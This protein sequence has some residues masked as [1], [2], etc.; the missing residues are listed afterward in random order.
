VLFPEKK[1]GLVRLSDTVKSNLLLCASV[2]KQLITFYEARKPIYEEVRGLARQALAGAIS[3]ESAETKMRALLDKI[4]E[5]ESAIC[6]DLVSHLH[7][8]SLTA[9][10]LCCFTLESYINNIAYFLVGEADLLG[11]LKGGHKT[12]ADLVLDAIDRLSAREKWFQVSR[13]AN[14]SGLDKSKYPV[15]DFGYLFN[16]RDDVVHDKAVPYSDDRAK[17]RYNGKFPDPVFSQLALKHANYAATVYW[18]M[19]SEL[20]RVISVPPETFHRHYNLQPWR[21]VDDR[22]NIE[23][24]IRQYDQI[25]PNT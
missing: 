9:I 12:S 6:L 20:H 8:Q 16:F 5:E 7:S 4:P 21:T 15:Q 23:N 2:T 14:S 13:I 17:K 25:A 24:L 1:S 11:L 18:D 10:L 22:K 19:V 3:H